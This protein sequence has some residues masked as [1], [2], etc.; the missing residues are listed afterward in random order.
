[1]SEA[2]LPSAEIDDVGVRSRHYSVTFRHVVVVILI[3]NCGLAALIYYS[4]VDDFEAM[5]D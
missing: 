1:M 3:A 4:V 2:A 5:M